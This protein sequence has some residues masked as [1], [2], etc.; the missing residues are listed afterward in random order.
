ML[1]SHFMTVF[2]PLRK[3]LD[4]GIVLMICSVFQGGWLIWK[5]QQDSWNRCQKLSSV[6][7]S[8]LPALCAPAADRSARKD[9]AWHLLMQQQQGKWWGRDF[10]D[11]VFPLFCHFWVVAF[12]SWGSTQLS[13]AVN[14]VCWMQLIQRKQEWEYSGRGKRPLKVDMEFVWLFFVHLHCSKK[15]ELLLSCVSYTLTESN[16]KN[17]L[18]LLWVNAGAQHEKRRLLGLWRE[19]FWSS[20]RRKV[21][22]FSLAWS[23]ACV[24]MGWGG[25]AGDAPAPNWNCDTSTPRSWARGFSEAIPGCLAGT[26]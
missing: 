10:G 11:W 23:T 3:I 26:P 19:R 8:Q 25:K 14:S 6:L 16:N 20:G 21:A 9:A 4:W 17:V 2:F 24:S 7:L 13:T 15:G 22:K 1:L 12:L 18:F 5:T